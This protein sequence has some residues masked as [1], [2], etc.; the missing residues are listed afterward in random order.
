MGTQNTIPWFL[1][2]VV[3]VDRPII[4]EMMDQSRYGIYRKS[5]LNHDRRKIPVY[6]EGEDANKLFH[7]WNCGAICNIDREQLSQDEYSRGGVGV[8]DAPEVSLGLQSLG[9][10]LNTMAILDDLHTILLNG[11][12]GNPVNIR[13]NQYPEVGSGCWQCGCRN[14]C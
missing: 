6:G 7:C 11:Q 1:P 5:H 9:E 4:G 13:H 8:L 14:Y 10:P 12:D 2:A 3:S